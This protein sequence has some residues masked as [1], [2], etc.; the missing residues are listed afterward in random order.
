MLDTCQQ[1]HPT[2]VPSLV[3]ALAEYILFLLLL[4]AGLKLQRF[5]TLLSPAIVFG[6]SQ[7]PRNF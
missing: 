4:C 6:F 5:N 1:I 3:E 2:W 7:L